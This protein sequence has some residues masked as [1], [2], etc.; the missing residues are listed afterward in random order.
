MPSLPS[1]NPSA[2]ALETRER[3]AA[4]TPDGS[5]L[6]PDLSLA[7]GRE[8]T[9]AGKTGLLRLIAA[10]SDRTQAWRL[11]ATARPSPELAWPEAP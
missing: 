5:T 4:R 9:G 7:F 2:S 10:E 3:V 1:Q 8:Q 11:K 6:F